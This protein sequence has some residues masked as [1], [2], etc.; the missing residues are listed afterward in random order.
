MSE[1]EAVTALRRKE[2]EQRLVVERLRRTVYEQPDPS[3]SPQ[4]LSELAVGEVALNEARAALAAAVA[5]DGKGGVVVDTQRGTTTRGAAT[6]GLEA[7]VRLGM[8]HIP[9]AI[10]HLLDPER[11]PLVICKVTAKKVTVK[12]TRRRVRVT[13]FIEGYSARAVT[14]FELG[15]DETHEFRQLPT[16]FPDRVRDLHELSRATLNV[17]VEDLDDGGAVEIHETKP[18]WM[19]ARNCAPLGVVDPG[20]GQWQSL[21]R[22]FGA[23]VT[24]NTPEVM[25]FLRKVVD[26]HPEKR[27]VG[28][29]APGASSAEE[30]A[31]IVAAQVRAVFDALKADAGI[32]YVNSVITHGAEDGTSNQ[33][34]RL[35]RETLAERQ[36]NCID[37]TLLFASLLEA[38][39]LH[40]AIV[41]VTGHAFL[42]WE[43][44]PETGDWRY[45]ETTM[46]GT[47]EFDEACASGK[48]T[49][50]ANALFGG[51]HLLAVADL[52][53]KD[54][55]TPLE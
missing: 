3:A 12:A 38:I 8:L 19:L 28:Y 34:V 46:I 17:L 53:V 51:L 2:Y 30:R 14:T 41:L 27:L 4:L 52:R 47:R 24:P 18:V 1:S 13:S 55:I 40:P 36:A 15:A 25:G 48:R 35:P 33:R 23:F 43:A 6:T 37:G 21:E 54:G 45:L 7:T 32:I 49:A 22:Y 10:Y 39:S 50:D 42:A 29:Q 26:H 31:A 16:L 11:N 44:W 5:S 20:T 9:T